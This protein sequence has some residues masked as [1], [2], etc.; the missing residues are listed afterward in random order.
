MLYYSN[1]ELLALR[2]GGLLNDWRR[3]LW[4]AKREWIRNCQLGVELLT[5]VLIIWGRVVAL[6]SNVTMLSTVTAHHNSITPWGKLR[7]ESGSWLNVIRNE[8]DLWRK[9]TDHPTREPVDSS[10][11]LWQRLSWLTKRMILHVW[12]DHRRTNAGH[13][14][15]QP[16]RVLWVRV[17]CKV[18]GWGVHLRQNGCRWGDGRRPHQLGMLLLLLLKMARILNNK[19]NHT[20]PR[21][22]GIVTHSHRILSLKRWLMNNLLNRMDFTVTMDTQCVRRRCFTRCIKLGGVSWNKRAGL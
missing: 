11:K 9:G 4:N 21:I 16:V 13:H 17:V 20:V 3:L 7:W 18:H 1:F 5:F 8:W 12:R 6:G 22:T 2:F 10:L 15:A 14:M 19:I